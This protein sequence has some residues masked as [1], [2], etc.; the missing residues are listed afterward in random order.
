MKGELSFVVSGRMQRKNTA[1][2]EP[3]AHVE[4]DIS[5]AFWSKRSADGC[6]VCPISTCSHGLATLVEVPQI[7]Y[8]KK[9]SEMTHPFYMKGVMHIS[10]CG[11]VVQIC[12]C[13]QSIMHF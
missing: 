1:F 7:S 10:D 5:A 6:S 11:V 8:I 4:T 2:L 9:E 3:E 12:G 13:T